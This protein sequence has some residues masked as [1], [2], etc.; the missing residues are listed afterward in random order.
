VC[1]WQLWLQLARVLDPG[2]RAQQV[3]A[4][5]EAGLALGEL[6]LALVSGREEAQQAAAKVL[7]WQQLSELG[8]EQALRQGSV[9]R[10]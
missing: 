5:G 9:S 8:P 3:P 7:G 10:R 2:G 4:L 1:L 6:G